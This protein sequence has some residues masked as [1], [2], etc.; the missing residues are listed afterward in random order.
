MKPVSNPLRGILLFLVFLSFLSARPS[1]AQGEA[2][3]DAQSTSGPI[4][5][6]SVRAAG[7][8][9]ASPNAVTLSG[10]PA[11]LW[12][13][14]CGP[15]AAGMVIG[16]WDGRPHYDWL[17]A[18]SAASQTTEVDEAIASSLAAASHYTDYA[19]PQDSYPTLLA[20]RSE[21]PAGDEHPDN[22]LADFMKTSRSAS[23]N[24]Y[25]WSW[26]SDMRVA[27]VG[28]FALRAHPGFTLTT[29]NLSMGAGAF[30]W[31]VFQAE[32]N[33]GRP[34]VLLVDT[35]GNGSTDHFITAI[36]YDEVGGVQRYGALNTWDTSLHWY[37]FAPLGV[38]KPWGIYG[39]TTFR[40]TPPAAAYTALLPLMV[41]K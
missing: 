29:D 8:M 20:D 15:T 35:D 36:G 19:L 12:R 23:G 6:A 7:D 1:R 18:G 38:G 31:S 10:V 39:A 17:I 40:I 28:Y 41:N 22:S 30:N 9:V 27:F 32:I 37:D 16:Y 3:L 5:P 25:G 26:F 4:P 2:P 13:H 33:A 24:Y 34:V 14:G 21:L 11:Y